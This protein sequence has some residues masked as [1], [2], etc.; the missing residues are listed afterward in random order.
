M[1]KKIE[2]SQSPFDQYKDKVDYDLILQGTFKFDIVGTDDE[3]TPAEDQII[4]GTEDIFKYIDN[5]MSNEDYLYDWFKETGIARGRIYPEFSDELIN[6]DKLLFKFG[7]S[8]L[9]AE[10]QLD[11]KD[12]Q[13]QFEYWLENM[14]DDVEWQTEAGW[15]NEE[16]DVE[17][18]SVMLK[19]TSEPEVK[20][21]KD[22]LTK[23]QESFDKQ[24]VYKGELYFKNNKNNF[25]HLVLTD[26]G[27]INIYDNDKL[28]E[29]KVFSISTVNKL[30][31]DFQ[32]D[33]YDLDDM[34]QNLEDASGKID[35]LQN[36]KDEVEGKLDTLM[37]ES[38]EN[39]FPS[40]DITKEPLSYSSFNEIDLDNQLTN[41]QKQWLIKN[42]G[43]VEDLKAALSD[44]LLQF[45]NHNDP[46]ISIDE[47]IEEVSK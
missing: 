15:S 28:L 5:L 12:I 45:P 46:V 27:N 2:E 42:V 24:L 35:E 19:R 4:W 34:K 22:D 13:E 25:K 43:T 30:C 37:N 16:E 21:L 11:S 41:E 32:N 3:V 1:T 8:K 6:E 33:G 20:V 26:E 40:T 7:I 18:T 29:T 44:L 17:V 31:E 47:Y 23:K 38:V 10:K 36:L 9:D 39:T 14:A